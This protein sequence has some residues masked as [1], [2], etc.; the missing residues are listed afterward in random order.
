MKKIFSVLILLLMTVS[1][2]SCGGPT[3]NADIWKDAI[4][5]DDAVLGD[6]QKTLTVSVETKEKTVVFT[7]LTD[8]KTVGEA[9]S[10]HKLISGEKGPYGLYV[11]VVNGITA[12][13]DVDQS[14]WSFNK[15]G[16]YMTTGVDLTEF[17]NG[18][19]FEFVYTGE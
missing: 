11:K 6:G 2:I 15:N 4:Y 9:L 5:T 7:I 16:E 3:E 1:I 8:K 10:E 18:D 13:Y 12:D 14:Y 19:K 17:S